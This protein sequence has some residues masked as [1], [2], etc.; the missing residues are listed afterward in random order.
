MKNKVPNTSPRYLIAGSMKAKRLVINASF[1]GYRGIL[2]K[3]SLSRRAKKN[4]VVLQNCFLKKNP[5]FF[6]LSSKKTNYFYRFINHYFLKKTNQALKYAKNRTMIQQGETSIPTRIMRLIYTR[7]PLSCSLTAES[8]YWTPAFSES[9]CNFLCNSS[10]KIT[11]QALAL[12]NIISMTKP[13]RFFDAIK[14][15]FRLPSHTNKNQSVKNGLAIPHVLKKTKLNT[16]QRADSPFTR[17]EKAKEAY[18]AW[19]RTI[20]DKILCLRTQ[21]KK[22]SQTI[23][24]KAYAIL[25]QQHSANKTSVNVE[26]QLMNIKKDTEALL[27]F[28]QKLILDKQT[29][30]SKSYLYD[31]L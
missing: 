19:A 12:K 1:S 4:S 15:K 6:N 18:I 30:I 14:Q 9:T 17:R 23:T 7:K 13:Y 2:K 25:S 24:E 28:N 26:H 21:I 31:F 5:V 20:T 10:V 8:R 22:E 27:H 29:P 11:D 3:A 16:S